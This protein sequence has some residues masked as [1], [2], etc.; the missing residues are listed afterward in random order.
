MSPRKPVSNKKPSGRSTNKARTREQAAAGQAAAAEEATPVTPPSAAKPKAKPKKPAAPKKFV[1]NPR[2]TKDAAVKPHKR[3]ARDQ[4]SRAQEL[5]Q[6]QAAAQT[7]ALGRL[8]EQRAAV[9]V[10]SHTQQV[11]AMKLRFPNNPAVQAVRPMTLEEAKAKIAAQ[12]ISQGTGN[13]P[14][15]IKF[16]KGKRLEEAQKATRFRQEGERGIIGPAVDRFPDEEK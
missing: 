14:S 6:G 5:A 4:S 12:P 15:N 9:M 13:P 11:N 2:D 3:A 1:L 7:E 8:L 16:A 10:H